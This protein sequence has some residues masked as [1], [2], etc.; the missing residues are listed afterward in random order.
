MA[1]NARGSKLQENSP[2][3]V[4]NIIPKPK[5]QTD[6]HWNNDST[7]EYDTW[8][9]KNPIV[10][11]IDR[12]V[13]ITQA[14]EVQPPFKSDIEKII[15]STMQF[16]HTVFGHGSNYVNRFGSSAE[17]Y[18][19]FDSRS[20]KMAAAQRLLKDGVD[21]LGEKHPQLAEEIINDTF[22]TFPDKSKAAHIL[23]CFS[24]SP[25]EGVQLAVM[26][27]VR[28]GLLSEVQNLSILEAISKSS[29]AKVQHEMWSRIPDPQVYNDVFIPQRDIK[30]NLENGILGRR[31]EDE[32]GSVTIEKNIPT[33]DAFKFKW[34][35][36]CDS[37]KVLFTDEDVMYQKQV[38]R[39]V[40]RFLLAEQVEWK[41]SRLAGESSTPRRPQK[42]DDQKAIR[43]AP[44]NL[45]LAPLPT[46]H[47]EK[48]NKHSSFVSHEQAVKEARAG[49]VPEGHKRESR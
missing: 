8:G 19:F 24:D 14:R 42:I 41:K 22:T 33:K 26:K 11:Y 1:I 15:K 9:E 7:H 34:E 10:E 43:P 48:P 31:R 4:D 32:S 35:S 18:D 25:H 23:K 17:K 29:H 37:F 40:E 45:P 44:I 27:Q 39:M 28:Q 21:Y 47:K 38:T 46:K 20:P 3:H 16:K 36:V 5:V 13:A 6:S 49:N 30:R 12:G 2:D